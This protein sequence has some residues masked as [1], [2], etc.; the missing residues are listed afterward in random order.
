[1]LRNIDPGCKQKTTP[2][3]WP[4]NLSKQKG[5]VYERLKCAIKKFGSSGIP[6]AGA[7]E[8]RA[9]CSLERREW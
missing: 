1:M 2:I 5:A 4:T 8:M 7:I 3:G 6:K 9:G